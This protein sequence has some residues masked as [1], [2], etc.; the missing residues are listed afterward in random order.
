MKK[1]IC[2]GLFLCLMLSGCA[3]DAPQTA[4]DG[5]SWDES[6]TTLGSV[7]GMEEKCVKWR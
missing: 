6:W 3:K 2:C 7:L 1:L 5:T 4:A